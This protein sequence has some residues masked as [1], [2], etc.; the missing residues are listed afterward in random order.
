LA[1]IDFAPVTDFYDHHDEA[2]ILDFIQDAADARA[3]A[4][5]LQRRKFASVLRSGVINV[6]CSSDSE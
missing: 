2:A 3:D 4:I 6:W 5:T 1:P